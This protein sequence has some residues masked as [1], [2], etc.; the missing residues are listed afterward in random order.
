MSKYLITQSLISSWE[1]DLKLEGKH[2]EF[3]KTLRREPIQQTKAMLNG[4][5]FENCL[6][7]VLNGAEI[8]TTHEWYKPITE[9][10]SELQGA[11]Q[12]VRL[13][14]DISVGDINFV[15]YGVLDYLRAG[16]IYDTKFSKTYKVGKYLTSPQTS[17]YFALV[18]EA[19]KFSYKICD[20]EWVYTET[21][22]PD[23]I[24]PIE[25]T[26]QHFINYLKR[27]SLLDVYLLNWQSKY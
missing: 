19:S 10:A 15:L 18:P 9:L 26:I 6:N 22:T 8:D 11:Q 24:E 23:E 16:V 7:A 27:T 21:Y 3:L 2:E 17:M 13:S 20:G 14:R 25:R 12:Q 5:R 4:I 1:W